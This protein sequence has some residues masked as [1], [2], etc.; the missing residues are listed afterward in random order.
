[1]GA[2]RGLVTLYRGVPYDLPFGIHL[3]EKRYVSPV[4]AQALSSTERRRLLDHQ[5]RSKSD[6]TDLVRNL[7]RSR[8]L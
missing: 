4:P 1:V 7:E 2:D 6:A 5:L 8:G 3:Y